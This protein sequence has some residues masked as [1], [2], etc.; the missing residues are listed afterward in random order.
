MRAAARRLTG[1]AR[2]RAFLRRA[3]DPV[4]IAA[5]NSQGDDGFLP[6]SGVVTER[7]GASGRPLIAHN[8]GAGPK[9]EDVLFDWKITGRFRP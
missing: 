5:W 7:V 8:I 9:V 2:P 3:N 4:S 1:S 6:H